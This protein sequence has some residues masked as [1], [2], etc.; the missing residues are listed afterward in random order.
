MSCLRTVG[1]G[2]RDLIP[3]DLERSLSWVPLPRHLHSRS[4]GPHSRPNSQGHPGNE[5]YVWA[6]TRVG[7]ESPGCR[8]PCRVRV[9]YLATSPQ[10]LAF[11][12]LSCP[13][14]SAPQGESQQTGLSW[15]ALLHGRTGG[16]G[17]LDSWWGAVDVTPMSLGKSETEW[18]TMPRCTLQPGAQPFVSVGQ[19]AAALG[20][21][22]LALMPTFP[23]WSQHE[24]LT[25]LPWAVQVQA[26]LHKSIFAALV[27]NKTTIQVQK[28]RSRDP[29]LSNTRT[30]S[31]I[32]VDENILSRHVPTVL[33]VHLHVD[34]CYV[35]THK[36]LPVINFVLL[37]QSFSQSPFPPVFPII[38]KFF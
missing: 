18:P 34:F 38:C 9:E 5:V 3:H 36:H 11:P 1:E 29:D 22:F 16:G 8:E 20:A 14:R 21:R 24:F 33:K 25:S 4:S 2:A 37:N 12:S 10:A 35:K 28:Q 30:H 19:A 13:W 26:N 17:D 15:P 7:G 6:K 32:H 27:C 31:D 23:R